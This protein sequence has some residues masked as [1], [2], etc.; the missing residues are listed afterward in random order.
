MQASIHNSDGLKRQLRV[1]VDRGEIDSLYQNKLQEHAKD[2]KIDGFRPGKVTPK[3]IEQKYGDSVHYEALEETMRSNLMQALSQENLKPVATPNVDLVTDEKDQDL[4]FDA[5]FEVLPEIEVKGLE[6]EEIELL[7]S[8]VSEADVDRVLERLRKREAEWSSVERAAQ[9]GDKLTADFKGYIDD[10]PFNGGEAT[11]AEILL[12]EGQMIE[13]FEEQLI[14]SKAG[15]E[16]SMDIT[17]PEDYQAEELAGQQAR[18]DVTV[19]KVEEPDLPEVDGEFLQKFGLSEEEG[20]E[21]FRKEID[22]HMQAELE[23]ALRMNKK[24]TVL[25]KLLDLNDFEIPDSLVDEEIKNLRKAEKQ[26]QQQE[27]EQESEEEEEVTDDERQAYEHEARRRVRLG[28]LISQVANDYDLEADDETMRE[29]VQNMATS[30]EN[31]EEFV[32]WY[33]NDDNRKAQVEMAA[34]EEKVVDKLLEQAN[35]TN[36]SVSYEEIVG[37]R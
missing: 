34:L 3:V 21:G 2:A 24:N 8:E 28:L 37:A 15:D 32:Q 31:P 7:D 35:V 9:E 10:E 6:G 25:E 14:G 27:D 23:S 19:K 1:T 17:F 22:K 16:F 20:I 12:G 4:V 18:F 36:K 29:I 13:G 33:L 30:Y 11:D 26:D 5:H